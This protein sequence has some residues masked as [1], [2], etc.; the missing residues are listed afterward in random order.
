MLFSGGLGQNKQSRF[1]LR[2]EL[3]SVTDFICEVIIHRPTYFG[4]NMHTRVCVCKCICECM[5]ASVSV[6][7]CVC[8]CVCVCVELARIVLTRAKTKVRRS[9][10][11]CRQNKESW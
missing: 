1:R 5:C 8:V 10:I 2:H 3:S 11:I 6:S 4:L 9:I 7:V